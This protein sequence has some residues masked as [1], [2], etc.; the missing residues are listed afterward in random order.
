MINRFAYGRLLRDCR[1]RDRLSLKELASRLGVSV[2]YLSDVER[3]Q[4][5]PLNAVRSA[6][7][8]RLFVGEALRLEVAAA[9]TRG[10]VVIPRGASDTQIAA[11]MVAFTTIPRVAIE[12]ARKP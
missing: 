12:K 6:R 7:V 8:A 3:G 9:R 2:S 1:L 4:R 5:P 11:A 10:A